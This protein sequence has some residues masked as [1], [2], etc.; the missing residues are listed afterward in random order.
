MRSWMKVGCMTHY[1]VISISTAKFQ[2][3]F[4]SLK[5][6]LDY[7]EKNDISLFIYLFYFILLCRHFWGLCFYYIFCYLKNWKK[8]S[9]QFAGGHVIIFIVITT[10]TDARL[11]RTMI[12]LNCLRKIVSELIY[13]NIRC[14]EV[15]RES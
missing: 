8:T 3:F 7:K 13:K 14:I 4:L 15:S 6:P 12:I 5:I 11:L 10:V 9:L 2:S 1:Q